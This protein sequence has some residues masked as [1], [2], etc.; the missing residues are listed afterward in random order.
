MPD[1][2]RFKEAIKPYAKKL[3]TATYW[4]YANGQ[5]PT[6]GRLLMDHPDLIDALAADARVLKEQRKG[7]KDE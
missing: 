4:R 5:L 1:Y 7:G 2:P 3:P 6:F